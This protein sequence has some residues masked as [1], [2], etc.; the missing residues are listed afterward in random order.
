MAENPELVKAHLRARHCSPSLLDDID[1]VA[2]L[3]KKR[4]I[5][6]LEGDNARAARKRDSQVIGK[7]IK[8]G[9]KEEAETMKLK[10]EE[11]SKISASTD[12]KLAVVD[13]E[14]QNIALVIPNL[15]DDRFELIISS[16][17]QIFHHLNDVLSLFLQC[18]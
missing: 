1:R 3:R 7:L 8:E 11:Y 6:I 12:D 14:I 10:I 4:S 16:L 13:A 5:Y 18:T 2:S 9:K 15:L 17:I